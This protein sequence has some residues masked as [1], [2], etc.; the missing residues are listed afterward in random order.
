MRYC[1]FLL[2][3]F[4]NVQ[5]I[6]S[7]VN[8]TI[9]NQDNAKLPYVNIYTEDG[10]FGTT[11]NEEGYYELKIEKPGTYKLVFQF[12]GYKTLKKQVEITQFPFEL[13]AS[14]TSETTSLDEVTINSNENPANSI[15]RNTIAK[16]AENARKIEAYTADFYSRGLWRIKNAPEKILGQEIGDLGGGLDSTRSGVVYL[17]ETISEIAYQ[18]PDDFK[19]KIIASK[20]SGDDNGF[21]LNS[22]QEAYFSFYENTLEINSELV[23][24]IADYAFNYYHYK[25]EGTF[26]D[27]NGNLI[28]KI[29]V[30]PKRPKDRVFSGFIY[31]VEDIWQ[32]YGVELNTT[33]QAIQVAP[34]ED[35]LFKQNYKYSKENNFYIQISQSVD[36]SFKI[37]GFGGDGRFVAVYSNYNFNPNFSR[38]SFGNEI[39]SFA[40]EASKKDSLFWQK[41]RP[42]PLTGEE[43][44]DYVKKDSIQEKRNSK[45]YK[46]SVDA[47]SNK[48]NLSD[49]LF[50]YTYSNSFEKNYLS[51]SGPILGT[52]FNT[53]QGWNTNLQ[54][55]YRQNRG[56]NNQ[57]FW[58][59]YSDVSYG[60]SEERFRYS[61]GFQKKF[62]NFQKPYLSIEGGVAA[63]QINNTIPISNFF[64]DITTIFFERNYLKLYELEY[65]MASYSQEVT[66][67]LRLYSRLAWENR[68]PLVNTEDHVF[69]NNE[70]QAYTSNNP[71]QPENFGSVPFTEHHLFKLDLSA[72]ITFGQKFLSY[73]TGKFNVGNDNYPVL[74]IGYE[75]GFAAEEEQYNFDQFKASVKQDV[76][77]GN[78]GL[79]S[80]QLNGGI[81]S[82][83][84]EISLVDYK[85]FDGNQTR[86]GTGSYLG[87]FNLMPYYQFSTNK[88]YAE[89]H[90]EQDF[91]GWVLGKLPLINKLNYNLILGL[92][93]LSTE[94][95]S[96]YTEFSVGI[97]NIGFGKYRFLRLDYVISEFNG[98]RDAAIIFGI[99][100]L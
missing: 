48:F 98:S 20:V 7:Q 84:D 89:F 36:F 9:T 34:V 97:D 44:R 16:R 19:E 92:H 73:P 46:D 76:K 15:I 54:L 49:L 67:G 78:K 75:K 77:L 68:K 82:N 99:K 88:N 56:E 35:L 81:F 96:P 33:G 55:N 83:A 66:N 94:A 50:G 71:F 31:I 41:I 4:S 62:N 80:Y 6:Y 27:D 87:K 32:I 90:A 30:N 43:I 39:L 59:L 93:R 72:T 70:D 14:L 51:I 21:S 58:R 91:K 57:E 100:I 79:F 5:L 74:S 65:A 23:S 37:F 40:A 64:N 1:L 47:V 3:L 38:K 13:N 24:P 18:D 53:V 42:I 45:A 28:N 86:I 69:I 2:F 95:R 25:L 11:T 10:S 29:Q 26:Y 60:F 12:L 61:A 52:H 8:G 22:A 17:S 85:H 63:K